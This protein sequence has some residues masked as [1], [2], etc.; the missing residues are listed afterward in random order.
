MMPNE[1]ESMTAPSGPSAMA[2]PGA[3]PQ[4]RSMPMGVVRTP[5]R[6]DPMTNI[7]RMYAL[8]EAW[9]ARDWDTYDYFHDHDDVVV[10]WPGRTDTPT[11]GGPAHTSE[12]QKFCAAF[13][14]NKVLHPYPVL[15]GDGD[16]TCFV[17]HFTGTFT[18]PFETPDATVIQP[19][20]K[21]FDVL[22]STTARWRDGKIVEEWLFFDNGSFLQQIGLA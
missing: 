5:L 8:D 15:F 9:N 7:E 3:A 22:F 21:S 16:F 14:D 4:S 13:P 1:E 17:T 6:L 18:A 11:L 10:Y 20:G 19:T 2:A 12:S